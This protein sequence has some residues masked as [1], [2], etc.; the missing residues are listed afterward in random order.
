MRYHALAPLVAALATLFIGTVVALRAGLR[1]RL[2]PRRLLPLLL[3]R[4]RPRR[5]LEPHIP[6]RHLPRAGNHLPFRDRPQ[7]FSRPPLAGAARLRV[8]ERLALGSSQSSR[9]SR[10]RP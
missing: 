9:A 7:R 5:V 8:P 1:R 3:R 4:S 2:E 6:D 10:P